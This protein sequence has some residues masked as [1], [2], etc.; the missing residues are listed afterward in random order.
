MVVVMDIKA[1]KEH[2]GAVKE[3]LTKSGFEIHMI[4]G[5][6]RLVI[7]A[8]GDRRLVSS[9]G[10]ETMPSVEAVIPILKPYKLVSL[11]AQP[12][13]TVIEV[14][15][16]RI[17]AGSP[18]L[19]AGPC[20]VESREQLLQTAHLVKEAGASI[21][22]GGA[23]KPRSSPY[24]FQGLEAEG[25]RLLAEVREEVG[26]PV[27]SEVVDNESLAMAVDHV[28]II[29]IGTRNMQ[30]FRLLKAV[31]QAGLPVVLKRGLSA[32]IEEWLMAAEYIASEGNGEVILC[33]R[34]IRTF[35]TATRNTL[36]I[37]AIPVVKSLSHL[38]V[39]VDPSHGTGDSRLVPDM[40]LASTAAGADG[41]LIEVHPDPRNA[42]CDGAQSLTPE[43]FALLQQRV[44]R[45]AEAVL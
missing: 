26:I 24:S 37:S 38:P 7:G 28:D 8:V 17:G 3:R 19:M 20:A 27:V 34:G 33:E 21:L 29:Q 36:D 16:V 6:N 13:R 41:L 45:V 40:A 35:E 11:E 9:L 23:Y 43:A 22:R 30:N 18:V 32:T 10:L 31:G 14:A 44:K 4:H 42:L 2:I 12:D 5:V 15:G 25:Y 1:P 39:I